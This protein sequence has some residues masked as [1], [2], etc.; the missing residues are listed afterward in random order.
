MAEVTDA[1]VGTEGA[2][3]VGATPPGMLTGGWLMTPTE[4]VAA[5]TNATLG[6][7]MVSVRAPVTDGAIDERA[8]VADRVL[9]EGVRDV[10]GLLKTPICL[11][12]Q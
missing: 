5:L 2:G 6:D 11:F 3:T 7:E 9:R 4:A 1:A 8:L 10:M 12:T